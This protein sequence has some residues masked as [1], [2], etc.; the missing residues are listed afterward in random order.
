[1]IEELVQHDQPVESQE[2]PEQ[3]QEVV[4][5]GPSQEEK[6]R[7]QKEEEQIRNFRAIRDA[8]ERSA[9]ERDEALQRLQEYERR[10]E[11]RPQPTSAHDESDDIDIEAL[12]NVK[13]DEL[14]EGRHVQ[15][16]KKTIKTLAARQK[17]LEQQSQSNSA[18]VRLRSQYNDFDKVMTLQNIQT[19]SAAYPELAKTIN[20]SSSLYDK[21]SSAYTLIKRFGIYDDQPFAADKTRA[22]ENISKPKPLSSISPQQGDT[23]LS[24]ANAFANGL[25]EELK[26]QLRAEMAAASKKY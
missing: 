4:Q 14:V 23:P 24:R 21:A 7:A 20:A 8:A 13:D 6:A 15:S 19:F 17:T 12:L 25:T 1:M 11:S 3:A 22:I 9:R 26:A 18:E 5:E 10:Y 2:Q 16:L